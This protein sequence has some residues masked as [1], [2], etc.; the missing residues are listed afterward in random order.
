VIP[1]RRPSHS[2]AWLVR[3]DDCREET[4]VNPGGDEVLVRQ[5]LARSGWTIIETGPRVLDI[6]PEDAARRR[7]NGQ[8]LEL[9]LS[10]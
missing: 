8:Q 5:V 3:C 4:Y 9:P 2:D 7:R 6:C 1:K 10:T